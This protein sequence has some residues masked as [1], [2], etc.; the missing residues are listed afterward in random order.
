MTAAESVSAK[1]DSCFINGHHYRLCASFDACCPFSGHSKPV[2]QR[3]E[4]CSAGIMPDVPDAAASQVKVK[5]SFH[6]GL[7][8]GGVIRCRS[9]MMPGVMR[10]ETAT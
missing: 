10:T 1:F 7:T 8:P 3:D 9:R 6:W 2:S 5:P 4:T